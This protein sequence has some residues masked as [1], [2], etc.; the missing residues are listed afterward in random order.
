MLGLSNDRLSYELI[1]DVAGRLSQRE[2]NTRLIS[3]VVASA[4]N[5]TDEV[6]RQ[7]RMFPGLVDRAWEEVHAA[8]GK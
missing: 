1:Q 4:R 7:A 5:R 6:L 8:S 3:R 2:W